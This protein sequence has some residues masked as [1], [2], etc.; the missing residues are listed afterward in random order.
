MLISTMRLL[1]AL[2]LAGV[3]LPGP[4]IAA[5]PAS[6]GPLRLVA[7][8]TRATPAPA[9]NGAVFVEIRNVGP[10]SDWLI[11]ADSAA[12]GMAGIHETAVEAGV[13]RMRPVNR[14]EIP[15]GGSILLKPGGLHIMLLKLAA[16]LQEGTKVSVDLV[17]ETAGRIT[18]AVP[19]GGPGAM[20]AP[21]HNR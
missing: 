5:E 4:G 3:W 2:A 8:W 17:F 7:P 21:P 16:P 18:L 6:L 19:V 13:M 15:P 10:E 20:A 9:A 12:A 11:A 14:V 1:F